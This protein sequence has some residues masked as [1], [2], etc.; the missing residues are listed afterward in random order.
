[1]AVLATTPRPHPVFLVCVYLRATP[2]R[3]TW[4]LLGDERAYG[5]NPSLIL[6]KGGSERSG[7]NRGIS[8]L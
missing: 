2:G 3:A 4:E 6:D 1:M 5:V 8:D 7:E